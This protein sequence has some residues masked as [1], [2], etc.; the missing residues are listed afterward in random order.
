MK[1]YR[2]KSAYSGQSMVEFVATITLFILPLFYGMTYLAKVGE[3][4]TKTHNAAR[5]SAW[6]RTIYHPSGSGYV[7]K[8]N[9]VIATEA[10]N[11]IFL[12]S[13]EPL[14][15]VQDRVLVNMNDMDMDPISYLRERDHN[16]LP[17]YGERSFTNNDGGSSS[18][19]P[20]VNISISRDG[21]SSSYL[22]GIVESVTDA[23]GLNMNHLY[24]ATASTPL[25]QSQY[26]RPTDPAQASAFDTEVFSSFSVNAIYTGSWNARTPSAAESSVRGVLPSEYLSDLNTLFEAAGALGARDFSSYRGE[27]ALNFGKVDPHR[28]P[29]QRIAGSVGANNC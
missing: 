14:D 25:V 5:Y 26:L 19:T 3:A 16:G 11:R 6:E 27:A 28:V 21:F 18:D 7:T 1:F 9:T 24:T 20:I 2:K 10:N 15:S 4:S 23:F 13:N 12:Q 8:T 17:I 29:C 22:T